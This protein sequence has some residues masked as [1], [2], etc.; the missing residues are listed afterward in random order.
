MSELSFNS[1]FH[2][3]YNTPASELQDCPG[4]VFVLYRT[5]KGENQEYR[6]PCQSLVW[7]SFCI[8]GFQIGLSVCIIKPSTN[9][10]TSQDFW[11]HNTASAEWPVQTALPSV[12]LISQSAE[13]KALGGAMEYNK[14]AAYIYF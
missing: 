10:S 9:H 12:D 14:K 1:P 7:F 4:S 5:R 11:S 13:Q 6:Q 3:V 8:G 2:C